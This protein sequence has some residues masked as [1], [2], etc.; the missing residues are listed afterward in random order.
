[1]YAVAIYARVIASAQGASADMAQML[2][3]AAQRYAAGMG[4]AAEPTLARMTEGEDLNVEVPLHGGSCYRFLAVGGAGVQDLAL[5]VYQGA[6]EVGS[7]TAEASEA[8]ASYCATADG[9]VRLRLHMERGSGEIAL[10]PFTGGAQPGARARAAQ[11]EVPVGGDGDDF[12]ARQLRTLH[13]QVGQGRRGASQVMRATL[14]SAQDR[15]FPVQLLAGRCYTIVAVGSPS[16]RDLDLY[17]VT[18]AGLE[19]AHDSTHASSAVITTEPCPRWDGTYTVR[20]RVFAGYGDV[21]IQ[22]FGN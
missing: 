15:V 17:L 9:S 7:D 5:H 21:A 19:Q 12:L 13:G 1:M 10:G 16:V 6:A 22:V 3:R 14:R 8:V 20:A 4:Q 2:D 18:P 11:P